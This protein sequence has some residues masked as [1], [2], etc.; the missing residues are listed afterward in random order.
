MGEIFEKLGITWQGM[1]FHLIALVVL[2]VALTLLLYNPIKKMIK[3]HNDKLKNIFEDNDKLNA[4][5]AEMKQKYEVMVSEVKQEAM[6][7]SAEATAK[8][9][10]RADEIIAEAENNASNILESAKVES[11]SYKERLKNEFKSSVSKMSV[12]IAGK[13]LEREV[14]EKDNKKIID[15]CLTEWE[16]K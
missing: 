8:A 5:S 13:V 16:Q 6:R 14:S 1:L 11:L 12:E 15:A 7:V 3:G 4:E 10:V 9:Q 2:I